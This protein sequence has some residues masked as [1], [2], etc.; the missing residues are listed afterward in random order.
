MSYRNYNTDIEVGDLIKW[1]EGGYRK[2]FGESY[3]PDAKRIGI[4]KRIIWST[5]GGPPTL[6]AQSLDN[7]EWTI[8]LAHTVI[9]SK[10]KEVQITS[11]SKGNKC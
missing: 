1:I 11:E 6:I 8:G 4:V 3:D 7:K 5:R 9:I 2:P 10:T